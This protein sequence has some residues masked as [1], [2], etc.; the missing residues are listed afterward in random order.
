MR[1][2]SLL[3]ALLLG[4]AA[5]AGAGSATAST[6][7]EETPSSS[8]DGDI[9]LS[10]NLNERRR[11]RTSVALGIHLSNYPDLVVIP[12]MP[13]LY[14]P[15]L[16]A[17]YF[18]YEGSFWV[19][20]DDDWYRSDWYNGPWMLVDRHEVP[21]FL[22]RIPVRYY[23][24]APLYFRPWAN[25]MPPR[26]SLRW[27][28]DWERRHR[29]WDRWDRRSAPPPAPPPVFQRQF[30]Q[31]R[32]PATPE[33]RERL[34]QQHYRYR[35]REPVNPPPLQP[36][37]MQPPTPQAPLEQPAPPK[38]PYSQPA[39]SPLPRP[40]PHRPQ[41]QSQDVERHPN[42]HHERPTERERRERPTGP[43]P[44]A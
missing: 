26:W 32:Y 15:R 8:A 20:A 19:F 29:N 35:P 12:G 18:F 14:D 6:R 1:T 38:V 25:E 34:R 10:I 36:R 23:N 40:E 28:K 39:P 33:A 43:P 7:A 16:S 31:E 4:G 44:R 11:S 27:G 9:G 5:L 22:L 21:V 3:G 30:P 2:L 41:E 42:P 13:V 17:N 24:R 37:P